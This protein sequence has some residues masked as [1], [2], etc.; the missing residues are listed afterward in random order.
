[1]LTAYFCDKLFVILRRVPINNPRWKLTLIG[2]KEWFF[3]QLG[4]FSLIPSSM[5]ASPFGRRKKRQEIVFGLSPQ[6][7]HVEPCMN[8][9]AQIA[10][11]IVSHDQVV[12]QTLE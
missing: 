3:F 4:N 5:Q 12:Y 6:R 7:F 1:M 2:F 8:L 9:M 10:E 11:N